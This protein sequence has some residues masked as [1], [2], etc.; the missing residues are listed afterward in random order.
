MKIVIVIVISIVVV[1]LVVVVNTAK[2][3]KVIFHWTMI[4]VVWCQ[5]VWRKKNHL[6][7]KSLFEWELFAF[8]GEYSWAL[9]YESFVCTFKTFKTSIFTFSF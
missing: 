6:F 7:Q 4:N 3:L 9:I 2:I 5:N 8:D 1:F